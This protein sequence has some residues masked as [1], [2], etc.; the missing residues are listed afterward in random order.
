MSRSIIVR[1]DHVDVLGRG[2]FGTLETPD[3][4]GAA[5]SIRRAGWRTDPERDVCPVHAKETL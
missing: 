4:L 2:C 3:M 1:C 5:S